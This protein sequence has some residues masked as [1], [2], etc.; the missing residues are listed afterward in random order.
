MNGMHI[1]RIILAALVS[2]SLGMSIEYP[3]FLG[4]A[5]TV[6]S[7]S[8]ASSV[9]GREAILTESSP[10]L[11]S[12]ALPDDAILVSKDIA[13]TS[14][15]EARDVI[16]GNKIIDPKIIG[17]QDHQ[18]DPLAKTKGKSFIPLSIKQVKDRSASDDKAQSTSKKLAVY[19]TNATVAKQFVRQDKKNE[20][21]YLD[22]S[23]SRGASP[24]SLQNNGYGAY[25]GT[26]MGTPAF[27]EADGNLFAQ[28]AKGV[29]DV[30][31]WQGNI[32]WGIVG[33]SGVEGAIIRIGYGWGNAPDSSARR[34]IAEC[35]RLGIP[36]GV[37]LYS[38]AY[39]ADTALQEGEGTVNLLHDLGVS[40]SDLSLP[41]YY[42]LEQWVWS[43]HKPP[44]DSATYDQIVNS[45]YGQ[46]QSAGYNNLSVYSYTSYLNST[47]NSGNIRNRTSWVA[48]YGSRT[49]FTYP[50]NQRCWQY[51]DNGSIKGI[52]SAVDLNACGNLLY[53]AP[54]DV[55][56]LPN[57]A[58]PNGNYYINT[59]NS[60]SLSIDIPGGVADSGIK[61][62]VFQ[63]NN[64][65]AQ[66]FSFVRQTDGSYVITNINSG[67]VLDVRNGQASNGATIW[68]YEPNGTE[69]QRWFIRDAGTCYYLQSSLGNWVLNVAD[70]KLSSGASVN[71]RGPNG[72]K[73]QQFQLASTRKIDPQFSYRIKS[74]LD[75]H[76]VFDIPGGSANN[77]VPVQLYTWNGSGA[78]LYNF[79][80]VGNGVYTIINVASNQNIEVAGG[81]TDSG[82][83]VQQYSSNGTQA[84]HWVIRSYE[85]NRFS[86]IGSASN[87]A[88]DIPG[89]FA[90]SGHPLQIYEQNG[91]D[92]QKWVIM[93][94][95]TSRQQLDQIANQ[96]RDDLPDGIYHI[97][98][99]QDESFGI[100]VACGS[101]ENG[102]NVQLYML[103]GTDAQLWSIKQD[104][105]G[106][107]IITNIGSGKVIDVLGGGQSNGTHIQQYDA[108]NTYAQKWIAV[109]DSDGG[110]QLISAL[111]VNKALDLPSERVINQ[112]QLQL[113]DVNGT[114][115]QR[116]KFSK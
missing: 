1:F 24:V 84:Q 28:Q 31:Q 76:L 77:G 36:F 43:G 39:D 8:G 67:K 26:Y 47:L 42:D 37:Y 41:V 87:K 32:N 83:S 7:V 33:E 57:A 113:Y 9:K 75:D 70:E 46:L 109:R 71:L 82:T 3:C 74:V 98:T 89:A 49:G 61:P 30:S 6:V 72:G 116:W 60:D 53:E 54:L 22:M 58:I 40:P 66:Q 80:Q 73:G 93:R 21:D 35:K 79:R 27:F 2:L 104:S 103:N 12:P 92:A 18:A 56:Q 52:S 64:S 34:N 101:K 107:K 111:N 94:E 55:R 68:Q 10:D 110:Y 112:N 106:Y 63:Y 102:A 85:Q 50:S 45:W 17:S 99:K 25:W 114:N 19:R 78:Q 96:H 62:Q 59:S 13:V 11:I 23:V 65:K 108:N 100:D 95:L 38:Y 69:A 105:Q 20:S 4:N 16:T 86:F 44:N 29:I 48:S 15:G 51:S 97:K 5:A 90:K 81:K 115:A 14:D 91:T 88:I